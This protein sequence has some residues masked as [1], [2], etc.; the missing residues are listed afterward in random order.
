[1]HSREARGLRVGADLDDLDQGARRWRVLIAQRGRPERAVPVDLHRDHTRQAEVLVG[2]AVLDHRDLAA[3]QLRDEDLAVLA[4]RE[5]RCRPLAVIPAGGPPPS[6]VVYAMY[7]PYLENASPDVPGASETMVFRV[8]SGRTR[9]TWFRPPS[10]TYVPRPLKAMLNGAARALE[11]TV[12]V[13]ASGVAEAGID[14]GRLP[15][16]CRSTPAAY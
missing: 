6:V 15:S 16:T 11:M 3:E 14:S 2:G 5:V 1:M 7:R 12:E 13:G 10:A 4:E 9:T 8:P